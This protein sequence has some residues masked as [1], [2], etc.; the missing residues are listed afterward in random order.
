MAKAGA[1]VKDEA[2]IE[3]DEL[4][5]SSDRGKKKKNKGGSGA[6]IFIVIFALFILAALIAIIGFNVFNIRDGQLMPA[7]SKI[8]VIGSFISTEESQGADEYEAY[9]NEDLI[10][11]INTLTA[12]LENERTLREAAE[13]RNDIYL[14]ENDNLADKLE[15]FDERYQQFIQ[16]RNE[17]EER[18]VFNNPSDYSSYYESVNPENAEILYPIAKLTAEREAE[19][20]KYINLVSAT[21]ETKAAKILEELIPTDLDLVVLV[22]RNIN[23]ETGGEILSAM[24]AENGAA[25]LKR[26][27]PE[28]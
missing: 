3:N 27:S 14:Q 9:T 13:K 5:V 8:P 12:E 11:K 21:D 25:V 15:G 4:S 20:K 7:L 6:K 28:Q 17:F 23:V 1:K 10:Q 19:L 2:V 26:M 16:E 18:I 24:S 22:M